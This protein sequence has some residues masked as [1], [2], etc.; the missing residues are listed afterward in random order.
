MFLVCGGGGLLVNVIGAEQEADGYQCLT[1][2]GA[3]LS[4]TQ[5]SRVMA[6]LLY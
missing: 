3:M 6:S 5:S 2:F 1:A 4:G